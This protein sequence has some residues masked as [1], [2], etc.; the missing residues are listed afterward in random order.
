MFE[1]LLLSSMLTDLSCYQLFITIGIFT[2]DCI[3]YGTESRQD[4][5]SYRIP[6]GVGFIWALLLGLGILFLPESPRYDFNH[7][8]SERGL[9]T[10]AKFYGVSTSHPLIRREADE[11][12]KVMEATRGDHPWYEAITGPRMLYRVGLAMTLQMLQQLTGNKAFSHSV[13]QFQYH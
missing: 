13:H 10:M 4:T 12:N 3:N 8:K 2:A 7:A 1:T 9:N 11:I 6:M 5:G